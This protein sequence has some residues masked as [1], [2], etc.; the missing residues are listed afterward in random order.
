MIW[1]F[2]LFRFSMGADVST[3][4]DVT[5]DPTS[6]PVIPIFKPE[7][8]TI[9]AVG[10]NLNYYISPVICL[11]GMFGNIC[12]FLIMSRKGFNKSSTSIYF[13]TLAVADFFVLLAHFTGVWVI[14]VLPEQYHWTRQGYVS[15][16][17]YLII[18][19]WSNGSSAM[20]LVAVTFERFL[21]TAIPLK[22]RQYLTKR[23]A[24]IVC[25]T[26]N[27]GLFLFW[28]VPVLIVHGDKHCLP[29]HAYIVEYMNKYGRWIFSFFYTY[30]ATPTIFL[31]NSFLVY[32]LI[33]ARSS[34]L[35][36]TS[37][38]N[39]AQDSQA[40]Y[41]RLTIMA[42]T[43]SIA[44]FVF[45]LPT[46]TMNILAKFVDM[47]QMSTSIAWIMFGHKISLA[48][49][50]SNHAINFPLYLM[51]NKRIK[52]EFKS[53]MCAPFAKLR[54][55]ETDDNKMSDITRTS[56]IGYQEPQTNM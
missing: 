7:W 56:S 16:R 9:I 28:F 26:I 47:S 41:Q 38:T 37:S 3:I 5:L 40:Q 45:T 43:V 36:M 18:F 42:V 53:M 51:T 2:F 35:K 46:T 22:T 50:A 39:T 15:C 23:N 19:G 8:K 49:R 4:Q 10:H 32:R 17:I 25:A 13:R 1:V 33:Q 11:L 30:F 12:T 52:A 29:G 31:L 6:R 20:I 27:V 34:R 55:S 48:I 24:K 54:G 21:I 44:Y 14:E